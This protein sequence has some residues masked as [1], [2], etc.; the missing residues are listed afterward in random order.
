MGNIVELGEHVLM[1]LTKHLNQLK[2]LELNGN[3][4]ITDYFLSTL[5]KEYPELE[6]LHINITPGISN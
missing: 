6:V 1:R 4:N 3:I 2:A 5:V